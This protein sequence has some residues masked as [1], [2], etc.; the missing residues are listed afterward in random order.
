MIIE[1]RSRSMLLCVCMLRETSSSFFFFVFFFCLY[2]HQGLPKKDEGA[3]IVSVHT[4][5]AHEATRLHP[6]RM[7]KMKH[8]MNLSN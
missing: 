1:I 3:E 8:Y 7:R 6:D 4:V 5:Y 2:K